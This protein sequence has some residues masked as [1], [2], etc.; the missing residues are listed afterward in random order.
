MT[1]N[2]MAVA[3]VRVALDMI[4]SGR[5]ARGVGL[6]RAAAPFLRA[7]NAG[8]V[9]GEILRLLGGKDGKTK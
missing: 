8:D 2:D 7:D 6:L 3:R 9:H 5:V 4:V 1:N